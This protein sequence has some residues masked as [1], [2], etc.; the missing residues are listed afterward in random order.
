MVSRIV[1]RARWG[2]WFRWGRKAEVEE[3][4]WVNEWIL[5]FDR[6]SS[7]QSILIV[8]TSFGLLGVRWMDVGALMIR[9]AFAG[10]NQSSQC[11]AHT[12]TTSYLRW[13]W[14][15]FGNRFCSCFNGCWIVRRSDGQRNR[16]RLSEYDT[17]RS[18]WLLVG[19]IPYDVLCLHF[20]SFTNM[21]HVFSMQSLFGQAIV[22]RRFLASDARFPALFDSVFEWPIVVI[23]IDRTCNTSHWMVP[24]IV[25][26]GREWSLDWYSQSSMPWPSLISS[27][28]DWQ[29][30][31]SIIGSHWCVSDLPC[32][33]REWFSNDVFL[34]LSLSWKK[35]KFTKE[36]WFSSAKTRI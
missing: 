12:A 1:R 7:T 31:L 6:V 21:A 17:L 28:I 19:F 15:R 2:F 22:S 35:K 4:T 30:V 9:G 27:V 24:P 13:D 34:S 14:L 29:V 8:G 11:S 33:G 18:F 36:D 5:A 20:R 25:L 23:S 26:R 16:P 32:E 3:D 10:L